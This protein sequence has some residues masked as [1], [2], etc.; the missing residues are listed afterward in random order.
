MTMRN[1]FS[2]LEM[3]IC[4]SIILVFA[5]FAVPKFTSATKT[6]QEAK[7]QADIR[8]I[9][10][11]AAL[12]EIDH[13]EFPTT[14]D[15]LVKVDGQGRQYLQFKPL[16]PDKEEYRIENGVVSADYN[17]KHYSSDSDAGVPAGT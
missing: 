7:V 4:V 8:T 11:A 2:I 9:S 6:A 17:D 3:L 5:S 10:N 16:T 1:G 12:Y 15:E 13:G 14:V